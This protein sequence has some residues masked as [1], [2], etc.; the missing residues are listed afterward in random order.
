MRS[1]QLVYWTLSPDLCL[2]IGFEVWSS[3]VWALMTKSDSW[4][5]YVYDFIRVFVAILVFSF[6]SKSYWSMQYHVSLSLLPREPQHTEKECTWWCTRYARQPFWAP[7]YRRF[8]TSFT[9]GIHNYSQQSRVSWEGKILNQNGQHCCMY[10]VKWR[11]W[12]VQISSWCGHNW[13][14]AWTDFGTNSLWPLLEHAVHRLSWLVHLGVP[15]WKPGRQNM[16][17]PYLLGKWNV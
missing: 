5:T 17:I 13:F 6:I 3:L 2:V 16:I 7:A 8:G 4:Y 1:C 14:P 15:S 12:S 10:H 11:V 9:Y